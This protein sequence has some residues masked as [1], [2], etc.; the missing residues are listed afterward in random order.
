MATIVNQRY[1]DI[2]RTVISPQETLNATTVVEINNFF[3]V[4][5]LK[6]SHEI[7]SG[8]VGNT[9]A[10]QA[11]AG[12]VGVVFEFQSLF[13]NVYCGSTACTSPTTLNLMDGNL[14]AASQVLTFTGIAVANETITVGTRV[15]TW[16][17]APAAEDEITVGA[18]QAASEANLTTAINTGPQGGGAANAQVTAVDGAGTV[19]LTA[20]T[21][22]SAGNSIATT[23]N[24]TNATFGAATLEGGNDGTELSHFTLSGNDCLANRYFEAVMFFSPVIRTTAGNGLFIKLDNNPGAGGFFGVSGVGWIV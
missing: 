21:A 3:G 23:T 10:G 5:Q 7:V 20:I 9:N 12:Q 2:I 15:Y 19:T 24:M 4:A 14:V 6:A 13:L 22:G 18:N 8:F 1:R 11:V 17:A 16:K